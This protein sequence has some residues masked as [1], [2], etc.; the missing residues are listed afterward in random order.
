MFVLASTAKAQTFDEWFK[1][2]ETQK[3]YLLQQIAGLKIYLD[4][5]EKGYN[6]ANKGLQ[7]IHS[8][9]KGDFNLHND[10]FNSLKQVN[11]AIKNWSR[12]A[13]IIAIQIKILKQTMDALS[14]IKEQKQFA[15]EE[16]N[17][18]AAVFERLLEDCLQDIDDLIFV[19]T[20]GELEMKD[21]ER[22]KRIENIFL[23]MKDKYAFSSSFCDDMKTLSIQRLSEEKKI[24][25][26]GVLSK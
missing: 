4:C 24:E 2:K 15:S 1:Q 3:K 23:D 12:I 13:D 6:I 9:K 17:Y 10:F 11:P 7:T 26:S 14:A 18:C 20:S 25:L 5:A 21:D 19:T 16:V 8:I 22:I